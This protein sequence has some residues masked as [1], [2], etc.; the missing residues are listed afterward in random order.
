MPFARSR[1]FVTF[2][3]V[4]VLLGANDAAAATFLVDSTADAGDTAP[5]DGVCATSNATCTLRAAVSEA[6]ALSGPDA[7]TVPAGTYV[8][9]SG[10]LAIS[11]DVAVNGAG[12]ATTIIDGNAASRVLETSAVVAIT[13][14]TVRNGRILNG[15]GGGILSS[16][17]G[18]LT[19]TD[20]VVT[21]NVAQNGGGI[22]YQPLVTFNGA[23][24]MTNVEVRANTATSEGGG[25][26]LR[27]QVPA[28]F[29]LPAGGTITM[30]DSLIVQNHA[31]NGGGIATVTN[32]FLPLIDALRTT[33][34]D[35]V[36]TSVGGGMF[37]SGTARIPS[38]PQPPTSF[39]LTEV[40]V[41]G[42]VAAIGGGIH[43]GGVLTR[44]TVSGNASTG[45][46]GGI[47]LRSNAECRLRDVTVTANVADSDANGSGNGGGIASSG[48]LC[49]VGNT[50][51]AANQDPGIQAPDCA[52]ELTSAGHVLLGNASGC[53]LPA[54]PTNVVGLDPELGPLAAN[55][56][57]TLTHALLAGSPA[58]DAGGGC[59]AADQRGVA[60]P[61]GPACDIGAFE[62]AFLAGPCGNG[63]L[64]GGEICD[65]GNVRDG[66]CC[67]H[68]C[69]LESAG[70]ACSDGNPCTDDACDG[71]G[72]CTQTANAG[73]CT[74]GSVCTTGAETCAGGTCMAGP[75]L[76]CDL[77]NPCIADSCEAIQ[78]CR[79]HTLNG[80]SCD[81]DNVC[82]TADVCH[83]ENCHGTPTPGPCDDGNA[84]TTGDHCDGATCATTGVLACGA[85]CEH[86]DAADGCVT[87]PRNDCLAADSQKAK[88]QLKSRANPKANGLQWSFFARS[89]NGGPGSYT[90]STYDVCLFD[91]S[92]GTPNLVYAA[93]PNAD[94]CGTKPCWRRNA[95]GFKYHDT[96]ASAAG[97]S[98]VQLYAFGLPGTRAQLKVK[99]KGATLPLPT[100]PLT[101]DPEVT[102]ELR[103]RFGGCWTSHFH[104]AQTNDAANFKGKSD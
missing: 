104:A 58:L 97:L 100:M 41:S 2:S 68:L 94:T 86:C 53:L 102:F 89:G 65:D 6:N 8:L 5:G 21:G 69:Q 76:D 73:S 81:D 92:A 75:A 48:A 93:R 57:P 33:V 30:T 20:V 9:T 84:C 45:D 59:T 96:T 77:G 74:D 23:V 54:D 19:L 1:F 91:E 40:T 7:I 17:S 88:L 32:A 71:A 44:S 101:K 99:A 4:L 62:A 28:E 56:G 52:G 85:T 78:G 79:Y 11:T 3:F 29:A 18:A 34:R 36:A 90:P 46:G 80:Q 14:V 12:A 66:D 24:T 60:R 43:G 51:I 103:D 61:A 31:V 49:D 13:G 83:F 15:C 10:Q 35:N 63:G 38:F 16:G 37:E 64:D 70:S 22:C 95:K 82:T 98:A 72:G 50:L 55:G 47:F 87:R 67:D 39:H 42:N 25:V 27:S 26:M